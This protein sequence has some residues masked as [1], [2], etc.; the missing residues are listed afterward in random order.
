MVKYLNLLILLS[1]VCFVN[2]CVFAK[3]NILDINISIDNHKF[4]PDVIEVTQKQKV[5]LVICNNDS[6]AEEFESLDL[7]REKIIRGNSCANIILAPL[8]KGKYEFVGEFHQDTAKG[9]I[10][11]K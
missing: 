1:V 2:S 6:S 4:L 11:V 5:R 3:D 9:Y 10:I 8:K 7:K